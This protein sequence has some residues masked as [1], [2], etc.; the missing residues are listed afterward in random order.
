LAERDGTDPLFHLNAEL[1]NE[2]AEDAH[3]TFCYYLALEAI[4]VALP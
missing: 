1:V 3:A 2:Q 4:D